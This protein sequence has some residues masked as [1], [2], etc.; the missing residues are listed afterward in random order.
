MRW[1]QEGN[2]RCTLLRDRQKILCQRTQGGEETL[3]GT[4]AIFQGRSIFDCIFLGLQCRI[5]LLSELR[6]I[7]TL[8]LTPEFWKIEC[9]P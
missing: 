2:Y 8:R 7:K 4:P 5:Y 9:S 6:V 1:T 3:D